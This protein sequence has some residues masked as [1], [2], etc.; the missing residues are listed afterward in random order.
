MTEV[1]ASARFIA[2]KERLENKAPVDPLD[3]ANSLWTAN[4]Q[5]NILNGHGR[6]RT[7]NIF[8]R[9][10]DDVAAAK[11]LMR[12]LATLVTS[13]HQQERERHQFKN[14]GIPGWLFG[15]L[16]LSAAGLRKLGTTDAEL[17][18]AFPDE[19][20][21]I[22]LTQS[23]FIDGM[24]QHAVDDLGDADPAGWEATFDGVDALLLLA[25]DGEEYLL[26][27][28]RI[29]IDFIESAGGTITGIEHGLALSTDAGEGIEHFGYVDGRSQPL[30]TTSDFRRKD[31]SVGVNLAV[32]GTIDRAS[33]FEN[34]GAAG[35]GSIDK[36]DPFEPL[37][38]VLILDPLLDDPDCYGSFFVF[39]KLEQNVRDFTIREQQ[40]ADKLGLKGEQREQ[41]GA[42]AVGRF[43]DGTPVVLSPTDGRAPPKDNNFRYD[44]A[45]ASTGPDGGQGKAL[46]CPFQAHIRK[47]NPRGDI[48]RQL[49]GATESNE[50]SRRIT[51][52]G[53]PYGRRNRHPDA[54]QAIDD[55]PSEGVGLL[56]MCFQ[57]NIRKQ[58]AF[59][60]RGWANNQSFVVGGTGIDPIIGQID[61][62]IND[63]AAP[64]TIDH[65]WPKDWDGGVT[66]PTESFFFGKFITTKGGEFFYAPSI[67]YLMSLAPGEPVALAMTM[68]TTQPRTV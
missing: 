57:A 46:H 26:R 51:R 61:D 15:G 7:V 40:L 65:T 55:L 24:A 4:L 41:A 22:R 16:V 31:D 17:T 19:L 53:I 66:G 9:L 52:R 59:M 47:T 23:N 28:A 67:P 20:E 49:P 5:G 6:D 21:D 18:T 32:D 63:P 44:G 35:K 30:Y 68:V 38:R 48:V 25:D 12:Q 54:F 37:N 29:V 1:Q 42:L 36:W 33:T 58:F 34:L 45:D 14:F 11:S 2:A 64:N 13:A 43:R 8:L 10:P 27:Q 39:R 62:G 50:R 60:Q 3:P 56:F